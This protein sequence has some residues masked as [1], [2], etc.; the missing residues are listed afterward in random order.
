MAPWDDLLPFVEFAMNNAKNA[1]TGETP[2]MLNSGKHPRNPITNQLPPRPPGSHAVLPSI[3]TIFQNRD[4]VLLRVRRLLQ[5]AQDRQK[6]YADRDRRPHSFTAG[7][8]VLLSTTN[9]SFNDKGR[10]K[11]FPKFVGPFLIDSMV[12]PN[13]AKLQLPTDYSIHNVFHVSLLRPFVNQGNGMLLSH[14]PHAAPDG[15]PSAMVETIL[16]HRDVRQGRKLIR[17]YL[18]HWSG[19]SSEHDSWVDASHMHPLQIEAY[20]RSALGQ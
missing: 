13:A 15:K 5:S 1:S 17:Q 3:E 11:L 20:S 16:S 6:S 10:R 18:I 12:G 7:Q 2:F 4:A 14:I 9:F 19:Q 8:Q